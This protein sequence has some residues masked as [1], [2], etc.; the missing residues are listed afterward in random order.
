MD[1]SG[2]KRGFSNLIESG[3]SVRACIETLAKF[4]GVMA[5][6]ESNECYNVDW[7]GDKFYF[8][9]DYESFCFTFDGAGFAADGFSDVEKAKSNR[10]IA[11]SIV[12]SLTGAVPSVEG[13]RYDAPGTELEEETIRF[14]AD[15]PHGEASSAYSQILWDA[16]PEKLRK[17]L[18]D[19]FAGQEISAKQWEDT[20]R[21]IASNTEEEACFH[22]DKQ[23]LLGTQVCPY[24]GKSL[25]K[26]QLVSK[27]VISDASSLMKLGIA[28]PV[29]VILDKVTVSSS[30]PKGDLLRM[31][32][33]NRDNLLVLQNLSGD[34]LTADYG[35]LGIVD[36]KPHGIFLAQKGMKITVS[37]SLGAEMTCM[38]FEMK[39]SWEAE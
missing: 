7:R 21:D 35:E 23:V 37:R 39:D 3:A 36:V 33:H 5:C 9:A 19:C 4:A 11:A 20:L 10:I 29:N 22:C 24:C 2:Y 25:K 12:Y 8:N 16:L 34:V 18:C 6:L 14:D 32:V 1:I 17:S 38:G 30:L 13:I 15:A 31:G 26:D 27:W 28:L